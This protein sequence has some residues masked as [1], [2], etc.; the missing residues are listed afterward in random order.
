MTDAE[1]IRRVA[2]FLIASARGMGCDPT[3]EAILAEYG[4]DCEDVI[5]D[6]TIEALSEVPSVGREYF[7]ALDTGDDAA[8]AELD[9]RYLQ[10]ALALAAAS[11]KTLPTPPADCDECRG[12]GWYVGYMKRE[13]CSRGCPAP[14]NSPGAMPVP[15]A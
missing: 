3:R 14:G 8:Y 2:D 15:W 10:P 6:W 11:C 13:R 12:S 9:R 1:K 4:E 7:A 5:S